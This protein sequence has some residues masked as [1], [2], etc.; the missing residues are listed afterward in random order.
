MQAG[1]ATPDA[2]PADATPVA[3]LARRDAAIAL[4]ALSLFAAADAWHGATGLFF[5]ALLACVDGALVGAGLGLLSHEWGHFAG[6]RWSGG[7]APTRDLA[8]IFP[9][10]DFDMQHSG[11]ASFRA[12]S[13]GGNLAHWSWV[14]LIVLLVPVDTPGRTSLLAGALGFA[15]FATT[16]EL[17]V[18]WRAHSGASPIES[19][20]GLTGEKLRRNR[21]LGIAVGAVA[22]LL[23]S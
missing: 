18:I 20:Q 22:F 16:S 4:A 3:K 12:M 17:P 9:I 2:P 1:D 5:A 23:L 11:A 8:K 15:V 13:W 21:N 19:F 6:A 10:F 7:I 14:L